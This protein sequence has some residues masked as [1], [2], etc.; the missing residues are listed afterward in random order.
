[1]TL[2]AP[3]SVPPRR[4]PAGATA[5]TTP[6]PPS[7]LGRVTAGPAPAGLENAVQE[8]G[9]GHGAGHV[10][11]DQVALHQVPHAQEKGAAGSAEGQAH[12]AVAGDDVALPGRRA[13]DEVELAQDV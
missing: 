2:P 3:S 11:A 5:P 8:V 12:G 9:Q 4:I 1:M 7:P 13:A 10:G 6:T